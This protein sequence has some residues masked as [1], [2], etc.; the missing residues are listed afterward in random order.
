MPSIDF[1]ILF[2]HFSCQLGLVNHVL[3][4]LQH[5]SADIIKHHVLF[6]HDLKPPH[7]CFF[8]EHLCDIHARRLE[9]SILFQSGQLL[10]LRLQNLP[11]TGL[12]PILL[13]EVH[14]F[15]IIHDIPNPVRSDNK[16]LVVLADLMCPDNRVGD[17]S[18]FSGD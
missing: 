1:L 17:D 10:P 13:Y 18:Q 8:T 3:L 7:S 15:F 2:D 6:R 16:E 5:N 9:L 4:E 11:L 12:L 14:D